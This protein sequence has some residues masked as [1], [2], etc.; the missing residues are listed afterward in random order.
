MG[1]RVEA[2]ALARLAT[3]EFESYVKLNKKVPPEVQ[4]RSREWSGSFPC[5]NSSV[6]NGAPFCALPQGGLVLRR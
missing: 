3:A 6:H 1:E 5:R 2:K 4:S